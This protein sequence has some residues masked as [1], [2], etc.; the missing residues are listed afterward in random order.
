MHVRA[1]ARTAPPGSYPEREGGPKIAHPNPAFLFARRA[2]LARHSVLVP[3]AFGTASLSSFSLTFTLTSLIMDPF[4]AFQTLPLGPHELEVTTPWTPKPKKQG[5]FSLQKSPARVSTS[6]KPPKTNHRSI[7]STSAAAADPTAHWMLAQS[8]ATP[9]LSPA[10]ARPNAGEAYHGGDN[11]S[12]HS[13]ASADPTTR[14][15]RESTSSPLDDDVLI[16]Q[17]PP[18]IPNHPYAYAQIQIHDAPSSPAPTSALPAPPPSAEA[19]GPASPLVVPGLRIPSRH[20]TNSAESTSTSSSSSQSGHHGD[21]LDWSAFSPT[22]SSSSLASS[23]GPCPSLKTQKKREDPHITL[24]TFPPATQAALD[25]TTRDLAH[26]LSLSLVYLVSLDLSSPTSISPALTLLSSYG[27][28]QPTP[29]FD[30]SLHFSALRAPEGGLMYRSDQREGGDAGYAAGL[31][32]P[33]MEERRVG[34]VLCGYTHDFARE[35]VERDLV[36]F[37]E[38]ARAL[39]EQ[40]EGRRVEFR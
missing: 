37:G 13:R 3:F 25:A 32:I 2:R 23:V 33:V 14:W 7:A 11:P 16:I 40:I 28:A 15:R 9:P 10:L 35:F 17:Q 38:H 6:S 12:R 4:S 34:Y 31:L 18:L 22:S 29:A 36:A 5:F 8:R 20:R 21:S 39:R 26:A 19:N 1:C 27:L 24:P 30:P